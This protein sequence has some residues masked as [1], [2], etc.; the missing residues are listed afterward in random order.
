MCTQRRLTG[1]PLQ[2]QILWSGKYCLL[3]RCDTEDTLRPTD[4]ITSAR[5]LS[6]KTRAALFSSLF[7]CKGDVKHLFAIRA[8]CTFGFQMALVIRLALIVNWKPEINLMYAAFFKFL[9]SLTMCLYA[10]AVFFCSA[11]IHTR[12]KDD[13]IC[14]SQAA[15]GASTFL[16]QQCNI[17]TLRKILISVICWT[18]RSYPVPGST[19]YPVI[20]YA[21]IWTSCLW[22]WI[23]KG[24]Q[25][26]INWTHEL[27]Q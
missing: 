12:R 22:L 8:T 16:I 9:S 20:W 7:R 27:N 6:S 4:N 17:L 21:C 15:F 18:A 25:H 5:L 3:P 1:A 2:S 19:F 11:R 24:K 26:G 13:E 14:K 23:I 10:V